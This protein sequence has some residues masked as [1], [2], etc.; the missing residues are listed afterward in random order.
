MVIYDGQRELKV[1]EVLQSGN[2]GENRGGEGDEHEEG[3]GEGCGMVSVYHFGGMRQFLPL[4]R[5]WGL[6]H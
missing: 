4:C 3:A 5:I 2:G 1:V 6:T